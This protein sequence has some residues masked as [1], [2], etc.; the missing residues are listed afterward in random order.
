MTTGLRDP[1]QD[2][3][4]KPSW[5]WLWPMFPPLV[6]L[7]GA[8]VILQFLAPPD[9]SPVEFVKPLL[10]EKG[11]VARHLGGR[12]TYSA[13]VFVHVVLCLGAVYYYWDGL[14]EIP[15]YLRKNVYIAVLI[16]ALLVLGALIGLSYA[17]M[18]AYKLTYFNIREVFNIE[19]GV[20]RDLL[21]P[22]FQWGFSKLSIAVFLPTAVGVVTV[23]MAAGI[24]SSAARELPDATEP[25]WPQRFK[26]RTQTLQQSFLLLS[27]VLVTSTLA[28]SLFFH[29]PTEM[30]EFKDHLTIKDA[31]IGYARGLSVFWGTIYTLTL[32]AVFAPPALVLR[33]RA[34]SFARDTLQKESLLEFREWL[35]DQ[36]LTVSIKRH[37]G[38][39]GVLLAPM[40]AGPIGSILQSLAS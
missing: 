27:A 8:A 2:T 6:P 36:D 28:A 33:Y 14:R 26:D 39:L 17:D 11:L 19:Q 18:A 22:V 20:G 5:A 9:L 13:V 35:A 15:G 37:L 3:S 40:M 10:A 23:I 38:N 7:L 4:S 34:R 21:D 24:A 16:E 12:M 25:E 29:L 32:I 31:L 30:F 1:D